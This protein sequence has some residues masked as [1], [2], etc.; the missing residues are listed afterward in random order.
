MIV[1]VYGV[2]GCGKTTV[3][4]LLS[5]RMKLPFYDGDEYHSDANV[6]KM[7]LGIPLT[8]EERIPWLEH[9]GQLIQQ[10]DQEK[11]AVLACSALN[12]RYRSILQSVPS[13]AWVLL[14]GTREMI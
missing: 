12:E 1:I 10:W 9:L 5:K 7:S 4:K 14:E 13:I 6:Q 11:E 8:D 3:G 2:T